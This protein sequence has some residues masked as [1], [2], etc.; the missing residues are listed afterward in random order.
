VGGELAVSGGFFQRP[1]E[2]RK[3]SSNWPIFASA[4]PRQFL[5]LRQDLDR[6]I[7]GDQIPEIL[8]VVELASRDLADLV[9]K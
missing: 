5:G 9:D 3:F 2:K 1:A 8:A 6:Q 4:F 7:L